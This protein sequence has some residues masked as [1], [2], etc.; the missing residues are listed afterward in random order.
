MGEKYEKDGHLWEKGGGFLGSDK[1]HGEIKPAD[2]N[3]LGSKGKSFEVHESDLLCGEH[4]TLTRDNGSPTRE[5][6]R[7]TVRSMGS[8]DG[9]STVIER[10]SFS[11]HG[12]KSYEVTPQEND[13]QS[14]SSSDD[15]Y[16]P[17]HSNNAGQSSRLDTTQ[18]RSNRKSPTP[19]IKKDDGSILDVVLEGVAVAGLVFIGVAILSALFG[20]SDSDSS[21]K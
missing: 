14:S 12:Q 11:Q 19:S 2:W 1:D 21:K 18:N 9:K 20:K 13:H 8:L 15:Y 16:E 4:S 17:N 7:T 5:G 10:D 3:F 6:A